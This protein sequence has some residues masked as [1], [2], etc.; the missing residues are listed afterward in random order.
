[1]DTIGKWNVVVGDY[2]FLVTADNEKAARKA[3][4]EWLNVGRLPSGT[5]VWQL[6]SHPWREEGNS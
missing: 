5:K 1:M 4:R 6:A 2:G 3:A